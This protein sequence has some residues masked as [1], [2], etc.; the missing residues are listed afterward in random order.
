MC[1]SYFVL[2]ISVVRL[3]FHGRNMCGYMEGGDFV[4]YTFG[5]S[6][7]FFFHFVKIA[8]ISDRWTLSS[9]CEGG[10]TL[11]GVFDIAITYFSGL[12]FC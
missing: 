8:F 4:G 12:W 9:V 5:F 7:L 10:V 1:F 3:C 6:L 2:I 11:N